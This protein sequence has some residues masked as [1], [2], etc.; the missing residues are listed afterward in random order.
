MFLRKRPQ[1]LSI[2][3]CLGVGLSFIGHGPAAVA[4]DGVV[5]ALKAASPLFNARLRYEHVDQAGVDENAH[6]GTLRIRAGMETGAVAATTGLVEFEWVEHL[7]GDY[8]STLNGKT[9]YPVV[10]DPQAVEVNRLQLTNR[11]LP[12]T[13]IRAG[14]QRIILD[15]SRFVGNVGWR[16]NEQTFDA[17]RLTH[18]AIDDVTVSVA[19][20]W[21]VNRIFG[22]DSPMGRWNGD[23]FLAN[24][25]FESPVG[26]LTGFAYRVEIR[27][28]P[29]L[30]TQTYGVRLAGRRPV[31]PSGVTVTYRVSAA[32]QSDYRNNPQDYGQPYYLAALGVEK[33]GFSAGLNWESLGGNGTIAVST[34]LATLHK[35]QGWA[36]VFLATPPDGLTDLYGEIG[37]TWRTSRPRLRL[38]AVYHRFEAER[39]GRHYG[40]EIDLVL[41]L[42]WG[43]YSLALK[44]ADY[45]AADFAGDRRK[46]WVQTSVGF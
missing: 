20:L 2:V 43:E 46:I 38:G 24:A 33:G 32:H 10:A 23:S 1:R 5:E 19:Y 27:E 6:A 36:D 11:S 30:S 21:Q 9:A 15:D 25:G 17:V 41:A 34:P 3:C 28:A 16:Q 8:N 12:G 40:D 37:Y 26:T 44:F 14:R 22:D 4:S 13:T 39:G 35:F 7:A 29:R 18:T 42:S 45:D 31:G